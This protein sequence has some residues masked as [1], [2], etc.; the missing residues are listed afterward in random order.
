M[1]SN[2]EEDDPDKNEYRVAPRRAHCLRA[3]IKA[4]RWVISRIKVAKW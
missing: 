3:Y 2:R 1:D 4:K